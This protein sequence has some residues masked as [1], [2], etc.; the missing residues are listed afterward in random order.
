MPMKAR[1]NRP[2]NTSGTSML[3]E[4]MI[5]MLPMPR[6]AATVSEITVPTKASVMAILSE[7]KRYGIERGMPT[8]HRMS[9]FEAPSA[10]STSSSSGSVVASPVAT[11]TTTGKMQMTSDVITAGPLSPPKQRKRDG[12]TTTPGQEAKH[13][14]NA[15]NS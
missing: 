15:Y 10:R 6:L 5:I 4:A 11:L 3:D 2:A 9:A 8:P 1:M 12:T 13:T 14:S 7:A